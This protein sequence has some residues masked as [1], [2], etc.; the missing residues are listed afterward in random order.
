MGCQ[1]QLAVPLHTS[2]PWRILHVHRDVDLKSN[3]KV[4][5]VEQIIADLK[6]HR[7]AVMTLNDPTKKD[8]AGLPP[9]GVR[10]WLFANNQV[11]IYH[12]SLL[13]Y[14]FPGPTFPWCMQLWDNCHFNNVLEIPLAAH[15]VVMQRRRDRNGV[16]RESQPSTHGWNEQKKCRSSR[17]MAKHAVKSLP[18]THQ[19]PSESFRLAKHLHPVAVG[20]CPLD[21]L[22]SSCCEITVL[23]RRF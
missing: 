15:T 23:D 1:S 19:R 9:R 11:K 10:P 5:P 4:P 17:W 2:E 7:P 21:R 8:N 14:V 18:A 12:R 3:T 22:T 20:I 13:D 16:G 6:M